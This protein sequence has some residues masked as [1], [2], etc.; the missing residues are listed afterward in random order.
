MAY[1]YYH[2]LGVGKGKSLG[3]ILILQT[4][5]SKRSHLF[6]LRVAG[7]CR[8]NDTPVFTNFSLY[9]SFCPFAVVLSQ[10]APER[11]NPCYSYYV[12]IVITVFS[13]FFYFFLLF[14]FFLFF[15]VFFFYFSLFYCNIPCKCFTWVLIFFSFYIFFSYFFFTF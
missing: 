8:H 13:L 6:S 2:T 12:V 14:L 7:W 9:R 15:S 10:W 4:L 3:K 11:F 1:F 5:E